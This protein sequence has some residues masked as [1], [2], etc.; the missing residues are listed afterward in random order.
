ML[1][2]YETVT[3]YLHFAENPILFAWL[4][5]HEEIGI[6]V[7]YVMSPFHLSFDLRQTHSAQ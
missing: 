7:L 5:S 4:I 1:Q 2:D 6:F 3:Y